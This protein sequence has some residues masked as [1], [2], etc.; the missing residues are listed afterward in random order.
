MTSASTSRFKETNKLNQSK[1]NKGNKN[2]SRNQWN[3]KQ[4]NTGKNAIKQKAA[5]L[6]RS[7]ELISLARLIKK[8]EKTQMTNVRNEIGYVI[9]DS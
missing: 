1:Q 9:T 3:R 4:V 6:Q 5:S 8:K 2:Q 7:I